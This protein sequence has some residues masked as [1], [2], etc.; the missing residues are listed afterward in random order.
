MS[1]RDLLVKLNYAQDEGPGRAPYFY[2]SPLTQAQKNQ[3]GRREQ[4]VGKQVEVEV[5]VRDGRNYQHS[6]DQ[7][8][9]QLVEQETTLDTEDFL[10]DSEKVKN[11]Y[12][13]EIAE[14]IKNKTGAAHVLLFH[15]QVR[16]RTGSSQPYAYRIHSDSHPKSARDLFKM[17]ASGLDKELHKGRFLYLNA[18]RNSRDKRRVIPHTVTIATDS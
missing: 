2:S 1:G 10:T 5:T 7:H 8:S 16:A 9:F 12:Y 3:T 17:L 13:P 6:L 18:W 11:I 14:L 15:H 4:I